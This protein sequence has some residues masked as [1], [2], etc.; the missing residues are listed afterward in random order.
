MI[1]KESFDL[2]VVIPIGPGSLPAF[3]VDTIN[4]FVFYTTSSY[5][6]ILV[7]DSLQ[8]V[9]AEVKKSFPDCGIILTEK[10]MGGWAGLYIS[11]SLAFR[12]AIEHYY[13]KA[14]LKLDTD[15]LI[16]ASK[17]EKET[18]HLFKTNPQ[19]GIAGQYP[20]DYHGNAWDISWPRKRILN[21]TTT[22]KFIRRPIANWELIKYYKKAL[23]NGYKT[24]ESVF[25]G[26]Y[27]M[28]A[29]FLHKLNEEGLLP[30]YKF[31]TL[32]LG[33]DHL[34]ALLA[35]SVGFELGDLSTTNLPFGC[36]WKGLPASPEELYSSGKKIIHST[37]YWQDM[38]EEEIRSW[39]REKRQQKE[40]NILIQTI[41]N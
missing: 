28:N 34:F 21:G 4:S 35:K 1:D 31:K 23:K 6:I 36:G 27:F 15:A 12:Y 13:F 9:A 24:G 5:K 3:V 33:E 37:R 40:Q 39:F 26:A 20:L 11:L 2:I 8:G 30:N 32:N 19:V 16:I 29:T 10:P 18:L 25:G 41:N 38:K 17:P 22:W 14:L 7:D